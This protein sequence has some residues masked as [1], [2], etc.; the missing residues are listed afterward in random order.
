M[1]CR[2]KLGTEL[3]L[4]LEHLGRAQ[5]QLVTRELTR[6]VSRWRQRRQATH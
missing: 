3:Q 1:V 5:A 6:A 4:C 2:Q